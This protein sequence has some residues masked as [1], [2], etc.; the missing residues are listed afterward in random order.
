ML[1]YRQ[2]E[3][4]AKAWIEIRTSS[5]A[6]LM[7]EHTITKLYGWVFYYQSREFVEKRERSKMLLGNGPIII[8]RVTG[9]IRSMTSA[10]RIEDFLSLY[11]SS[12][13]ESRMKLTPEPPTM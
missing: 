3:H 4:L 8:D 10:Q 12:I 7:P 13:P 6:V 9:D 2:A 11:E 1:T 5:R